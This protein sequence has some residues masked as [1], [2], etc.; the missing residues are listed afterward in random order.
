M[1]VYLGDVEGAS[2]YC[3]MFRPYAGDNPPTLM[4]KRDII[5]HPGQP[6]NK[7]GCEHCYCVQKALE[8]LV[9]DRLEQ[10]STKGL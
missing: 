5:R 9:D 2:G 1:Y 8:V 3:S 4:L 7:P 10:F 6:R